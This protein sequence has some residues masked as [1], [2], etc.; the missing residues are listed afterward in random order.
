M[1]G[2]T[3][4][5]DAMETR[6][7]HVIAQLMVEFGIKKGLI[8]QKLNPGIK[9]FIYCSKSWLVAYCALVARRGSF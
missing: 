4:L 9:S 2:N 7:L 1:W 6:G 5:E 3:P 8:T